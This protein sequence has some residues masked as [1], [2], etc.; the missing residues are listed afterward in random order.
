MKS[1]TEGGYKL[2][3]DESGYNNVTYISIDPPGNGL[4]GH[5]QGGLPHKPPR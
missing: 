2:K 3:V 1:Q 5:K 4:A